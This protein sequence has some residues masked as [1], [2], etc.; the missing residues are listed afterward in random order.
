MA[1]KESFYQGLEEI[2][3]RDNL[4]KEMTVTEGNHWCMFCDNEAEFVITNKKHAPKLEFPMCK[5]CAELFKRKINI[6]LEM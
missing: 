4:F 5:K 2:M 6:G 1:I 3:T